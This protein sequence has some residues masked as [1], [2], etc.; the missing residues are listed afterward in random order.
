MVFS[1]PQV[2]QVSIRR[3]SLVTAA[4][5]NEALPGIPAALRARVQM[6]CFA[7]SPGPLPLVSSS[8]LG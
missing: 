4:T 2:R 3:C 5:L 6:L 1:V 8:L 7:S